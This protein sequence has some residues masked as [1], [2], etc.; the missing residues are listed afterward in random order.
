MPYYTPYKYKGAHH[1]VRVHLLSDYSLTRCITTQ[2]TSIR[3]RNTMFALV[4]LQITTIIKCLIT[5]LTCV[6]AL[7]TLNALMSYKIALLKNVLLHTSQ[8]KERSPLCRRL[9]CQTALM[10]ECLITYL[11]NI[12]ALTTMFAW[13]F[14][15]ITSILKFLITH[16]N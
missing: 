3:A 14:L 8:V 7:T 15:R 1:Y 12:R 10:K 5:Y 4:F 13:V 2:I 16:L 6:R 11:T 9:S